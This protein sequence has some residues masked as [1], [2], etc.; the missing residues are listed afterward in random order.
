MVNLMTAKKTEFKGKARISA[1][2]ESAPIR[3]F[4]LITYKQRRAGT[5]TITP[6]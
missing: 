1:A 3:R 6:Q 5:N 4:V 2:F